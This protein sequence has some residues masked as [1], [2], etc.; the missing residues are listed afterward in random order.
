MPRTAARMKSST[1]EKVLDLGGVRARL[2]WI[3]GG[4]HTNGDTIIFVEGDG[5]LFA[6]DLLMSRRYLTFASP[7]SS[8][9]A[10]L[11]S[12]DKLEPLRPSHIVPCH[13]D[14]GDG[15]LIEIN[16]K[17]LRE[18]Q[19][20]A[21]ALKREGKSLE[22]AAELITTE[23]R[24]RYPDWIKY[25]INVNNGG[26]AGKGLVAE[27]ISLILPVLRARD[28]EEETTVIEA[29]SGAD[30]IGTSRDMLSN[31]NAAVFMIPRL[32]PGEKREVTITVSGVGAM[33]GFPRASVRWELPKLKNGAPN[34]FLMSQ[35]FGR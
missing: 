30:Y 14:M 13:G 25:T 17:C 28:P 31:T 1:T 3:G 9:R 16:R 27:H 26:E 8:I 19:A 34:V 35:P 12:Y 2:Q 18:L 22:E 4:T 11:D 6:G 20:R 10:W 29:T 24:A 23:F 15:S 32:G 5:V 33:V 7:T 21:A